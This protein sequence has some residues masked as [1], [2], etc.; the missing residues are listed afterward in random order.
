MIKPGDCFLLDNPT[1]NRK[2]LYIVISNQSNQDRILLVNVTTYKT[3][4]DTSCI[5][6]SGDHPFIKHKSIINYAEPLEPVHDP[7]EGFVNRNIIQRAKSISKVVLRKVQEGAK[8]SPALPRKFR[9][10]FR[11]F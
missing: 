2:H 3:G 11:Y 4:K 7:F 1:N 5:L 8:V 6:E 9:K 10:Y